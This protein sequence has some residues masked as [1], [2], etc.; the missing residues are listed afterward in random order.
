MKIQLITLL[1]MTINFWSYTQEMSFYYSGNI[2]L[3]PYGFGFSYMGI[4]KGMFGNITF[5]SKSNGTNY[6]TES[7]S[8]IYQIGS[9]GNVATGATE[10]YDG[11]DYITFNLGGSFKIFEKNSFKIEPYIG[12]GFTVKTITNK[13]FIQAEDVSSGY[14][15]LGY[16]W[17]DGSNTGSSSTNINFCFG[18]YIKYKYILIGLGY[19]LNPNNFQLSLGINF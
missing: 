16:Y 7:N 3:T 11:I 9:Y 14:N 8:G 5:G 18:S 12:T 4:K 17:V 15:V 1:F 2:P 13:T 19:H 6:T 10:K